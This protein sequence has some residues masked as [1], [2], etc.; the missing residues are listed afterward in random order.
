M[1][2]RTKFLSTLTLVFILTIVLAN[3]APLSSSKQTVVIA[4]VE[5]DP[6]TAEKP[7]T[8]SVY[9]GVK[10]AADQ[11]NAL[12]QINIQVDLYTDKN[13]T[14]QAQLMA[15]EIVKSNAVAVIGHSSIETSDAAAEIYDRVGIPVIN[16][17]PVTEHLTVDDPYHFNIT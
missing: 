15:S 16:V 17:I 10:L 3:C 8:Q 12:E 7:N 9:A 14:E 11:I 2:K 13:E 6:G 1:L 5:A 4:V